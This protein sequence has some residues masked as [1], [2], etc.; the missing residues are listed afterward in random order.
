VEWLLS[1]QQ[2]A[3]S[4]E[5]PALE[6]AAKM[7]AVNRT[8][9]LIG[10]QIG[11]FKVLS[12]LG[13]GEVYLAQDRRLDRTIALKILPAEFASDPERLRRFTKEARA[14]VGDTLIT[15]G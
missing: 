14:A 3:E 4:I 7:M 8:E 5:A 12:L 13:V 11:S 10:R 1:Y 6:V 2:P 9:T 15:T